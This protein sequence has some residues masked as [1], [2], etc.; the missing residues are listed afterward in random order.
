MQWLGWQHLLI[1]INDTFTYII[2]FLIYLSLLL[3]PT[4]L[5]ASIALRLISLRLCGAVPWSCHIVKL[6]AYVTTT[7]FMIIMVLAPLLVILY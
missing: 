7:A 1:N 6:I 5:H 3:I 2:A 4:V